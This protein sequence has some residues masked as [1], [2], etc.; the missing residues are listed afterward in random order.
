MAPVKTAAW[1]KYRNFLQTNKGAQRW[2]CKGNIK[3]IQLTHW[4]KKVICRTE[5]TELSQIMLLW[6]NYKRWYYDS[7]WIEGERGGVSEMIILFLKIKNNVKYLKMG[8]SVNIYSAKES[9][10]TRVEMWMLFNK[11]CQ[12]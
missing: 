8:N 5:K 9:N 3:R 6:Y 1:F 11:I 7:W 12:S 2:N 10:F 4:E